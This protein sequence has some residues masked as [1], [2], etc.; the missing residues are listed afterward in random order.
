MRSE[1]PPKKGK[2]KK[3][4]EIHNVKIMPPSPC[5]LKARAIA[6]LT[7]LTYSVSL[8]ETYFRQ[9]LSHV[10]SVSVHRELPQVIGDVAKYLAAFYETPIGLTRSE[11]DQ[12][13]QNLA[14]DTMHS[15]DVNGDPSITRLVVEVVAVVDYVVDRSH[16]VTFDQP[17]YSIG[18]KAH[19]PSEH[20]LRPDVL[21]CR[22]LEEK[23]I[24]DKG[25]LRLFVQ[26]R[27]LPIHHVRIALERILR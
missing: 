10:K 20:E 19:Q 15:F 6:N 22:I 27:W 18:E 3:T 7:I 11:D 9:L 8:M 5:A 12:K 24:V 1:P 26:L 2:R 16:I 21:H 17:V 25:E 23:Q 14:D 13:A 4:T